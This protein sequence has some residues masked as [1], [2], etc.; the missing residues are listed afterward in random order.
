MTGEEGSEGGEAGADDGGVD[1][2]ARPEGYV[3]VI[4]WKGELVVLVKV[5]F[6]S[7]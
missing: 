2:D 5:L 1:F 7:D 6:E 3:E 4:P